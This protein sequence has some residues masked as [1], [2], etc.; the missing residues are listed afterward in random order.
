MFAWCRRLQAEMG[1]RTLPSATPPHIG[2][3]NIVPDRALADEERFRALLL[4]TAARDFP[5]S[6]LRSILH[7]NVPELPGSGLR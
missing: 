6:Q 4:S 1:R 7:R 5:R 3:A 2:G